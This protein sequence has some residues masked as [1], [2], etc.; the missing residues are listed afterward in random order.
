M[1]AHGF[2]RGIAL[3]NTQRFYDA[4]EVWEDVWRES[5][6]LEKK[7]LQGLIQSAV[8]FHHYSTGN[9]AGACS[10]MRRARKNLETCPEDLAE[11]PLHSLLQSLALWNAALASGKIPPQHPRIE[12]TSDHSRST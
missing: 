10:L 2:Y 5:R 6:G 4:H 8:A 7:F 3:F 11:I 1:D 12:L 9:I